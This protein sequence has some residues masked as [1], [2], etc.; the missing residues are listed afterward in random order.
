MFTSDRI[1]KLVIDSHQYA[2]VKV[3]TGVLQGSPVP[4]ILVAIYLNRAFM[5]VDK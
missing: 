5:E 1:V 4:R 2:E 3:E